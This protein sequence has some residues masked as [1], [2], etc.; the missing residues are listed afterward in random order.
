MAGIRCFGFFVKVKVNIVILIVALAF[1]LLIIVAPGHASSG[2]YLVASE[3]V[4]N[5]DFDRAAKSYLSILEIDSA[6][7]V[8]L[9]E[10][11]IFSVLADDLD[12]AW[13]LSS[14]I[15]KNGFQISSSGLVAI[16]RSSKDA[17]LDRV[18]SLLTK[19]EESLPKFLI[20]F[21]NGWTE[22]AKGNFD[23]G[24][25][26]FKKLDGTM[27]YLA[28]YN[29]AVAHAMKGDFVNASL[30]LKEVEGKNLQLNERQLRAQAQI[31]SNND[32]IDKA[33]MLLQSNNLNLNNTL[34]RWEL[35][36][37]KKGNRIKFDA[38]KS[39]T[40]ALASIFYLMGSSS[41]EESNNSIAAI[42]YI[43][44]AEFMSEEK[45]YYN[46]RLAETFARM[47]ALN[48]S[49]KK[50]KKV[51]SKSIFY[52]KAQLGIVD[53][54]VKKDQNEE[55]TEVLKKLIKQGFNEF[56]LFDSLADIFRAKEDYETAIKYYNRALGKFD[57][58]I[59]TNKWATFF[60]RGIA[61]D[62]VGNWE[63]AKVDLSTAL[64]LYPNHPEVLNYF[65]YSLIE[66]N[67]SL[68]KALGMI[69]DAVAQKPESGYIID[70]LAWGLFR[71]G[72]YNEAIVPMEKAVELEPHDPIVNDHLGD[73][74]WMIGRKREARFQWNRALLFGPTQENK[75]K[76]KKKLRS[77]LTDL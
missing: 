56:A 47:Q 64:R 36:Q 69:E 10:A 21:V 75:E 17:D 44:L 40:D 12:S 14:F 35:G 77:G 7:T 32:E 30:Y 25:S 50:Y 13:R 73:I 45:D 11:L 60:V 15:E 19:Y 74:L 1:N 53:N 66:R 24:I 54:L 49:T 62:Q 20:S 61:H 48:Y 41:D 76:I 4:G 52:L 3:A 72:H 43:Q 31:Y 22:I 68:D 39:S 18:Q 29:C 51:P 28:L 34:F 5:K 2:K 65:G 16:A 33:I 37:L 55:G 8:V 58:E 42:F 71:L 59:T 67:E 63:Q 70:S 9:Q 23:S 38:F 57:G 27:R 26:I 46:L 6:D